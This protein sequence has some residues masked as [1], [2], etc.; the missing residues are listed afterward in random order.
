MFIWYLYYKLNI[1]TD[2]WS[3][4]SIL[5]TYKNKINIYIKGLSIF[6]INFY[7][8]LYEKYITCEFLFII[9]LLFDNFKL[10]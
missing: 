5:L 8:F 6:Y 4:D 10:Y 1:N 9:K 7:I 3:F 2:I